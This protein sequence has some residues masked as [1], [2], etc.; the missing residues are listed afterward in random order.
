M[1]SSM[2]NQLNEFFE[3]KFEQLEQTEEGSQAPSELKEE[4][5]NSLD[6]LTLLGDIVGLFTSD[7]TFSEAILLDTALDGM[8]EDIKKED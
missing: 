6:T 1:K 2:Q 5:F 4:V 7:F 8:E 3:K